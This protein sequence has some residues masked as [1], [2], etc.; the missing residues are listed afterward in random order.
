[1]IWMVFVC[2]NFN[3]TPEVVKGQLSEAEALYREAL[4]GRRKVLGNSVADWL[5]FQR[6]LGHPRNPNGKLV[7]HFNGYIL[8]ESH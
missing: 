4:Q 2:F 3:S 8:K 7:H 1:M 6:R 5:R